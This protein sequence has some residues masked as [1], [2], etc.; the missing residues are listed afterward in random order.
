[1]TI[2]HVVEP[3]ASGI[4]VFVKSLTETMPND[5]HII[6]HG[7]RRHVMAAS[8]VKK[9]FPRKNIRFVR[10]RSAQ[11]S[12]N[13]LKDFMAFSELYKIL[14]RLKRKNL[15]DAVHLHSSKSGLIGRAACRMAGIDNVVYT[16]NGAPFL[17]GK[18]P[19]YNFFYQQ[20]EK[21][22][23]G[24]GGRVICCSESELHEYN[25]IGI[26]AGYVNNG[27]SIPDARPADLQQQDKFRI[28]TSGRIV[29]QKNPQLFNAI[30]SYFQEFGNFEFI[31]AGD[32]EGR[33]ELTAKNIRV[34]GWIDT[35]AVK[36]MVANADVYLS[37]S[38][39]EGLS[40]AVLE[41]LALKKPML[42]TDCVGNTDVIKNG[43]NGDLFTNETEAIIKILNYY[44]NAE[45]LRVM[46]EY[47]HKIC[48]SEFDAQQ[49]FNSY[50]DIYTGTTII[51]KG[52]ERK[53]KPVGP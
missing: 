41:A 43:L 5:V 3:F 39:Y 37:T 7:E 34:T 53:K 30:A 6:L 18:N 8:E 31:W 32:G 2:L 47:S 4:A 9:T 13:P 48:T 33:Q 22:G 40:F 28:I 49:N 21:I 27:I 36:S 52:F 12:L 14:R 24:F 51:K 44:N 42:L 16:P 19:L 23:H 45:M 15:V 20:L 11:R 25:R 17:A 10:W 50:R 1:M 38:L 26:Q 35:A 46:G 29:P